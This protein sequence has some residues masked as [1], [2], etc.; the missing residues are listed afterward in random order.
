[1]TSDQMA[2]YLRN[3]YCL[4]RHSKDSSNQN[5]SVLVL[6]NKIIGTGNNN[7]SIGVE[8]TTARAENRPEKYRYFEHAERAAIYQAARAGERVFGS[9]MYTPWAAC[10][11]CA[12]GI[13]NS[14]VSI[15]VVHKERMSMTPPRWQ[16][17]VNEALDMLREA[18][19]QITYFEGSIGDAPDVL[20]N[21]KL[22]NPSRA[23]HASGSG[24]VAVEMGEER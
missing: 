10:C 11:D 9:V 3:A 12:R 14:G 2:D 6:D 18:G 5:G 22:W 4:A 16:D 20:V 17:S 15:L 1:M 19:V 7:F 23:P 8:F 13:I 21:G 24:N